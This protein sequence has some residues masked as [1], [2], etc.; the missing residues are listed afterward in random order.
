MANVAQPLG[1]VAITGTGA[2][3]ARG[4]GSSRCFTQALGESGLDILM[5]NAGILRLARSRCFQP[6]SNAVQRAV[7]RVQG[8]PGG[9]PRTSTGPN[10]GLGR[11][12]ASAWLMLSGV[13]AADLQV[14]VTGVFL[15]RHQDVA[16]RS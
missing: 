11:L 8:G 9:F 3:L 1:A 4:H 14:D 6:A 13:S 10:S 16:V 12:R 15:E 7:E 2:G 5:S